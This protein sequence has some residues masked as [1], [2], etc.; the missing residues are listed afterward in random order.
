MNQHKFDLI[1]GNPPYFVVKKGDVDESFYDLIDGRPN[2]F[3]LFLIHALQ[4][5]NDNGVL[6]FVL[7]CN[8]TNCVYYSKVRNYIYEN[9]AIIDIIDCLDDNFLDTKQEILV[10]ILQKKQ[11]KSDNKRFTLSINN[12]TVFNTPSKIHVILDL[13]KDSVSLYSIGCNVV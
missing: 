2:I 3:V 13:Y 7:P 9:F 8:F 6:A 5:L 10:F 11:D 4:K 12:N 1:I